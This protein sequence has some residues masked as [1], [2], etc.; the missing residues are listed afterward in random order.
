MDRLRLIL[1]WA[2]I[3]LGVACASGC[4]PIWNHPYEESIHLHR[5]AKLEL[6]QGKNEQAEEHLLKQMRNCRQK[7]THAAHEL[8][9][10]TTSAGAMRHA[11][12]SKR[13]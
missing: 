4:T 5:K 6:L 11:E 13:R 8:Q 1:K 3:G 12:I 9:S 2:S 7:S 10:T